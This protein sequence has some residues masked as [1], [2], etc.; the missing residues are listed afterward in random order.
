MAADLPDY[1]IQ[2]VKAVEPEYKTVS[3]YVMLTP[4]TPLMATLGT[5][6]RG[7]GTVC[8]TF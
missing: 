6:S 3:A 2:R 5:C 8:K 7:C 4:L 1:T